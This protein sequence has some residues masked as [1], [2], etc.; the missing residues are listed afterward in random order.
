MRLP[1]RQ[2]GPAGRG[3]RDP[4]GHQL[5]RRGQRAPQLPRHQ[6]HHAERQRSRVRRQRD[7]VRRPGE[8]SRLDAH[9][10]CRPRHLLQEPGALGGS[11]EGRHQEPRDRLDA[12]RSF[13][14]LHAGRE[15]RARYDGDVRDRPAPNPVLPSDTGGQ[16]A[17]PY[18]IVGDRVRLKG[19][20]RIFAGGKVTVDRSD[21]A[22]RS[23][24]L[25]L[26]TGPGGEGSLVG[27]RPVLRGLGADSFS[28]TGNRIDL[29]LE[30]RELT[31]L[32]AK[33]NGKAVSKDWELV[34]DT[35]ALDVNH[36]KLDQTLAWG[37]SL[38]PSATSVSYAMKA[39]SLVLDTPGQQL[40]EVRGFGRA[41]LG[42]TVYWPTKDRDWMRGDTVVAR[43]AAAGLGRQPTRRAQ[44]D[45]GPQG[46]PVLS[47]GAQRSRTG[48]PSINYAR[49]DV[50][51][52]TMKN[53]PDTT[54]SGVER[55]DIRGKVDGVQLE[56]ATPRRLAAR[57]HAGAEEADRDERTGVDRH[58]R[59]SR[60]LGPDRACR[61]HPRRGGQ[62]QRW[63]SATWSMSYRE[64]HIACHRPLSGPAQVEITGDEVRD[65]LSRSVLPRLATEGWIPESPRPGDWRLGAPAGAPGG[66]RPPR[67]GRSSTTHCSRPPAARRSAPSRSPPSAPVGQR[68]G[69]HGPGEELQGP[70]GR[71]PRHGAGP[72]GRDRRSP[73]GRTAR[74][75]RRPS[76]LLRG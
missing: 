41:W 67:P 53:G 60:S 76:T 6:D 20:D 10:G 64:A 33:G 47:P 48:Q 75:R 21:F 50:I 66:G 45:R 54:G 36:R 28:I 72:A 30:G 69:G 27:G 18:A 26:D 38:K 57:Y 35:I 51:T 63:T 44:P 13:A 74:E 71:G 14:R 9:H 61:H 29:K 15:G 7:P 42:G 4:A 24:S 62:R 65:H 25:R 2:R 56:A 49:G 37:D 1:D 22:S 3:D 31:Y 32:L 11:G 55:V 73:G 34:A 68:P 19:D 70:A 46:R 5:L 58:P 8:V 43:F 23:D 39:D 59:R 16:K 12:D 17:E 52:V 40:R